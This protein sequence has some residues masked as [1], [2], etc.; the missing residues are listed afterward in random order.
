VVVVVE[1]V[2]LLVVE[3]VVLFVVVDVVVVEEILVVKVVFVVGT[4]VDSK[5]VLGDVNSA[6]GV[7]TD[8]EK[9]IKVVV[10]VDWE[11][12]EEKT[13]DVD[14]SWDWVDINIE[15]VDNSWEFFDGVSTLSIFDESL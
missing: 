9:T 11:V 12:S 5:A 2:V 10:K 15:V 4:I 14:F 8:V 6:P 1:E 3:D 7:V 13:L